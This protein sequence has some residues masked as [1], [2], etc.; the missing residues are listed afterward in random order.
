MAAQGSYRYPDKYIPAF[1]RKT[2][3][4]PENTPCRQERPYIRLVGEGVVG[5]HDLSRPKPR[6]GGGQRAFDQGTIGQAP[7]IKGHGGNALA[8]LQTKIL[9]HA[10]ALC[11]ARAGLQPF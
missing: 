10:M 11:S 6:G 7:R 4:H 9:F 2:Q 5:Q 8:D 3:C 1:A